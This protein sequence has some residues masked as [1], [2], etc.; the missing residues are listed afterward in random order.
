MSR[1]TL[2]VRPV[3]HLLVLA[4]MCAP[5][6]AA[7]TSIVALPSSTLGVSASAVNSYIQPG[8]SRDSSARGPMSD[9]VSERYGLNTADSSASVDSAGL[10]ASATVYGDSSNE[11]YTAQARGMAGLVNPFV[12]VPQA[13]FVGTHALV[14]ITYSFAGAINMSPSLLG[15]PTCFGTVDA[16]LGVDGMSD[17]FGFSGASSLGTIGSPSFFLGGVSRAGVLQAMLPVNTELFLR[18]GLST[19]VHCQSN[20][21]DS[22]GAQALFGGTLS[23]AAASPDAV[24]IVWGLS[25]T[26][27]PEP[28]SGLLL[29]VGILGLALRRATRG[30]GCEPAASIRPGAH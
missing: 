19:G 15:C 28:S 14:R 1:F 2:L 8:I 18:A 24:D 5:L 29:G 10:H 4:S 16:S 12:L 20:A 11:N 27:V 30:P 13:G 7:A 21:V 3:W 9:S 6:G 26:L 17:M 23:Y 25:P 22:C